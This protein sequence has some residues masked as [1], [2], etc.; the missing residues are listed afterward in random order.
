MKQTQTTK[1]QPV[2][3]EALKLLALE[4]GLRAAC[5]KLGINEN[6][7]RTWSKRGGWNLQ[8]AAAAPV[9]PRCN[10]KRH[11]EA[12][13]SETT[14]SQVL[15]ATLK[16]REEQTRG[17][18][19]QA[20]LKGSQEAAEL[21]K[22]LP[23]AA[24][25]QALGAFVARTF[26]WST[27]QRPSVNYYGD[28]NTLVVCD[29]ARRKQLIEQ[30]QR[31]LEQEATGKVIADTVRQHQELNGHKAKAAVPVILPAPEARSDAS[32][33]GTENGTVAQ[34]QSPVAQADPTFQHMQSIGNAESWKTNEP[35]HQG[36]MFAPYPEE[37]E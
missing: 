23:E 3:K 33:A 19:S 6:T 31:L 37:L 29:E 36:G 32:A 5:R 10:E 21:E 1:P 12:A 22:V 30:R 11:S 28:V 24:R 16:E 15:V 14:P 18:M 26:G 2:N 34:D 35:E 7:G 20:A 8:P 13:T 25:L 9:S 4:I 27:D 17:Y